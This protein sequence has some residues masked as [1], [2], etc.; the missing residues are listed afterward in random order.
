MTN[1]IEN[2]KLFREDVVGTFT[3]HKCD[4]AII[5]KP[6]LCNAQYTYKYQ[7]KVS[8]K[9][10]PTWK[11]IF[12][13]GKDHVK[14]ND[15]KLINDDLLL[16]KIYEEPFNGHVRTVLEIDLKEAPIIKDIV[17]FEYK[18]TTKIENVHG[19]AGGCILFWGADEVPVEN[20]N[21]EVTL[22]SNIVFENAHPYSSPPQN[23]NPLVFNYQMLSAREYY[24]FMIIY[25][26]KFFG[27]PVW[28]VLFLE[29]S[30][31]VIGSGIVTYFLHS[32]IDKFLK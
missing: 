23:G 5:V 20:L 30:S 12:S 8:E 26:K 13:Y 7:L 24:S 29:K 25:K 14:V 31:W 9:W 11:E 27:M 2:Q 6:D 1:P 22:P 28:I 3:I 15:C 21:I 4:I 16:P 10:V 17:H 32:Q 18:C 19:K